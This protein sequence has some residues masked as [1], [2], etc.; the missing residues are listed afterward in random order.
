VGKTCAARRAPKFLLTRSTLVG[1]LDDFNDGGK[2]VSVSYIYPFFAL[3]VSCDWPLS[4]RVDI[5]A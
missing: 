3:S 4:T 2:E 5:C 1:T